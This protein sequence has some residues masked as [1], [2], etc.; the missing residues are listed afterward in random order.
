MCSIDREALTIAGNANGSL[1]FSLSVHQIVITFRPIR[2]ETVKSPKIEEDDSTSYKCATEKVDRS[3]D[4]SFFLQESMSKFR[5]LPPPSIQFLLAS[6]S[7]FSSS[8]RNYRPRPRSFFIFFYFSP[9]SLKATSEGSND[10]IR[11]Q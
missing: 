8:R 1:F 6:H 2:E 9:R 10:I 7:L 5:R 11:H 3:F 4:A